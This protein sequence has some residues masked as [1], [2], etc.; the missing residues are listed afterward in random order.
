MN[1]SPC[2]SIVR[3]DIRNWYL[4]IQTLLADY[5][6]YEHYNGRIHHFHYPRI[7]RRTHSA[8][9]NRP[10]K[11]RVDQYSHE[12][13][14]HIHPRF[15]LGGIEGGNHQGRLIP[16]RYRTDHCHNRMLEVL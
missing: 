16:R 1:S 10:M 9:E 2:Y 7:G 8:V 5:N 15:A 14:R 4:L 3:Q 13:I 6:H 12:H 11:N